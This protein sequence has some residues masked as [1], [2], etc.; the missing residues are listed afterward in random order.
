MRKA[1]KRFQLAM[2]LAMNPSLIKYRKH[3]L[4]PPKK[5]NKKNKKKKNGVIPSPPG[6]I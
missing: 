3:N 4:P 1:A 5:K 6:E 2:L